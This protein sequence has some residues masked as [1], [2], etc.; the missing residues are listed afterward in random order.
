MNQL[1]ILHKVSVD[2]ILPYSLCLSLSVSQ[3][4]I[5]LCL[6]WAQSTGLDMSALTVL[7]CTTPFKRQHSA[8][9]V[10]HKACTGSL[11]RAPGQADPGWAQM[12]GVEE[13]V[14]VHCADAFQ[15]GLTSV[16]SA[17]A[18]PALP[19][20]LRLPFLYFSIFHQQYIYMLKSFSLSHT[21]TKYSPSSV[22]LCV[23]SP[24][25]GAQ[26]PALPFSAA[27]CIIHS[28]CPSVPLFTTASIQLLT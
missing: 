28:I 10:C 9:P 16:S 25:P 20:P 7:Q 4:L 24:G 11:P 3:C 19:L 22:S 1:W 8:S 6:A 27:H 12:S 14:L 26:E 5:H 15:Y 17:G 23:C 2:W 21:H 18:Q 13:G